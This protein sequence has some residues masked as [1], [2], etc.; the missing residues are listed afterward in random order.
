M[1]RQQNNTHTHTHTANDRLMSSSRP[2]QSTLISKGF[3]FQ[4]ALHGLLI[5][6]RLPVSMVIHQTLT[7]KITVFGLQHL[8]DTQVSPSRVFGMNSG[9][10]RRL[11]QVSEAERPHVLVERESMQNLLRSFIRNATETSSTLML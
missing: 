7:G 10:E 3:F 2:V 5:N 11:Q 9:P 6:H 1:V 8:K 4:D